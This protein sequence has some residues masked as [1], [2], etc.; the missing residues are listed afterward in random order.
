MALADYKD[1]L[2]KTASTIA[3]KGK[4]CSS[5]KPPLPR[6]P[7][8]ARRLPW[9]PFQRRALWGV[10]SLAPLPALSHPSVAP[11]PPLALTSPPPALSRR[12]GMSL[13]RASSRATSRPRPSAPA[14]SPSAW[15]TPRRTAAVRAGLAPHTAIPAIPAIPASASASSASDST[16]HP[17]RLRRPELPRAASPLA[18]P[19]HHDLAAPD[20]RGLLFTTEGL[21]EYI[22]GAIL[23]EETLFQVR[24]PNLSWSEPIQRDGRLGGRGGARGVCAGA[25][26]RCSPLSL[27]DP[28][29]PWPSRTHLH[30]PSLPALVRP[31]L[32]ATPRSRSST[33]LASSRASRSTPA[34]S[35]SRA[36]SRA[37]PSAPASTAL[38]LAAPSTTSAAL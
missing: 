11:L 38:A 29:C 20:W 37:R 18:G 7:R 19:P 14:S 17:H 4:V 3:A 5:Y 9:L 1:E 36:A 23:F 26:M 30:P 22:S 25:S 6:S 8:G 12:P 13:S 10:G 27:P 28:R 34:S 16:S 31:T 2:A 32:T 15:R 21:G 35:R 33:R 24:R